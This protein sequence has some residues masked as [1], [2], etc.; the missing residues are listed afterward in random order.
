MKETMSKDKELK[1]ELVELIKP[2]FAGLD[3]SQKTIFAL[4][5]IHSICTHSDSAIAKIFLES[6][7]NLDEYDTARIVARASDYKTG[8]CK[9][10]M[11]CCMSTEEEK[12]R[13]NYKDSFISY[14]QV[15]KN[16]CGLSRE[17]GISSALDLSC[18]F[19]FLLW[20]GYFSV[21]KKHAYNT[22]AR[23]L[24]P[25]FFSL[26]VIKGGG[27]CLD[28]AELLHNYLNICD[29]ESAILNCK[30]PKSIKADYHPQIERQIKNQG[31]G[32]HLIS[33]FGP[34]IINK[35]GNHSTV[36]IR[37]NGN[38]YLFCPTNIAALN[39]ENPYRATMINGKG[40]FEL[41]PIET[42]AFIPYGDPH[43]LYEQLFTGSIH[44]TLSRKDFIYHFEE[45]MELI[46]NHLPLLSDAYD[47]IHSELELICSQSKELERKSK[48][49]HI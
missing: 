43:N 10:Y 15:L 44:S 31:H 48:I 14:Y 18:L 21:T 26:N 36:L 23:K 24:N 37:E 45:I 6:G 33:I 40:S 3:D 41:K 28:Y 47:E 34:F 2:F 27:V 46:H 12:C 5:S 1:K 25:G 22:N 35:I 42:L 49:L 20:N 4:K 19:T 11:S 16:Y 30:V 8:F 13:K 29:K 39:L 7:A 17:L 32:V 38:F 9:P